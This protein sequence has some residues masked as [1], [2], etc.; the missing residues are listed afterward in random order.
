M[1]KNSAI[2]RLKGILPGGVAIAF[3][4]LAFA[5]GSAQASTASGTVITNIATVNYNDA[6]NVPQPLVTAAPVSV[7]VTLVASPVAFGTAPGATSVNQGQSATLTYTIT[8]T[9]NG[10]DTYNVGSTEAG[11]VNDSG[12]TTTPP[13]PITLGGTTLAVPAVAGNTTITVPYDQNPLLTS[14]N[15]LA[16]GNTIVIG[17]VAYLIAAGGITKNQGGVNNAV[18]TATLTLTTAITGA[19]VPAGSVVGQQ[20][21]FTVN[22]TSGNVTGGGSTG[23]VSVTTT[24]TGSGPGV[25]QGPTAITVNRPVLT[26]AKLVSVNGTVFSGSGVGPPGA[27]LT[28]QIQAS[29]GG[30]SIAQQVAFTDVLPPYLTYVPGS[31]KVSLTANT[32]AFSN[33][34]SAAALTDNAGNYTVAT[35]AAS[36]PVTTITYN[37]PSPGNGTVNGG[38]ALVLYFQA[39]IN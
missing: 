7:T 13:G 27:T 24:V 39:K 3:A 33:Y 28:Y 36:P 10:P 25:S 5:P 38:G 15:G 21:T 2:H 22:V 12:S 9:A 32:T 23:T 19:T 35:S 6:G 31:G 20:V 16:P 30:T 29:N 11:N 17:G 18:N 4:V 1:D 34:G 26:V 37:P 8:G 14:V